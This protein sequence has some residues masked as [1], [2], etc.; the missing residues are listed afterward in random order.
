MS[1]GYRARGQAL[2]EY[3]LILVLVALAAIVVLILLGPQIGN[4]FSQ[5]TY[6]LDPTAG[7]GGYP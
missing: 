2:V 4:V 6:V 5:I 7:L 3:A 1:Y